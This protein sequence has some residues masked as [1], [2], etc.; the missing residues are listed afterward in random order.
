MQPMIERDV[1]IQNKLGLHARASACFVAEATKFSS[2]IGVKKDGVEV[3]GKS[4]MGMMMLAAAQGS[5][6]I[7]IADGEDENEALNA[8]EHVVNGLFGEAE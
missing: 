3:N 2:Y 4:I 8:L 7:L 1:T 6:L 5:Q